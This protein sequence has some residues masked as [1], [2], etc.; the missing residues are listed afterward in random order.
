[1]NQ[2]E[3]F[4]KK[5]VE[6]KYVKYWIWNN[7]PENHIP[8]EEHINKKVYIASYLKT[9]KFILKKIHHSGEKY[10]PKDGYTVIDNSGRERSFFKQEVRL[11]PIEYIKKQTKKKI[12]FKKK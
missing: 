10:W 5:E 1:M 12:I 8:I 6:G 11:H 4:S 7:I 2:R 3:S 9:D